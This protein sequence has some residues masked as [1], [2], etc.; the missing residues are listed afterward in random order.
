MICGTEGG[1]EPVF[2]SCAGMG[3]S[4]GGGGNGGGNELVSLLGNPMVQQV[5]MKLAQR[6]VK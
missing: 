4:P 5:G 6:L 1:V 2:F 3:G